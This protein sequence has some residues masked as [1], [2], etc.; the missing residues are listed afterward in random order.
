[1]AEKKT[2]KPKKKATPV[3]KAPKKSVQEKVVSHSKPK[4][5]KDER[6]WGMFCHLAAFAGYVVP[7]GNIIGPLIIW[8]MKREESSFIDA[9]GKESLNFQISFTIYMFVAFLL[10]FIFIGFILIPL[11]ILMQFIFIIVASLKAQDGGIYRYPL[12]IRFV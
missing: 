2:I 10:I 4:V 9:Q 3:K 8:L 1:M 5:S 6:N 7:F 12:S 11:L